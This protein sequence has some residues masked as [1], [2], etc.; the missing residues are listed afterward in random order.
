MSLPTEESMVRAL[1]RRKRAYEQHFKDKGPELDNPAHTAYIALIK[2]IVDIVRKSNEAAAA[3]KHDPEDARR[4]AD[5]VIRNE[6][7]IER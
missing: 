1:M 6:Y 5:E 2:T 7:G 4:K 3:P